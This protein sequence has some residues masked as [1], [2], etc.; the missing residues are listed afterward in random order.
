MN[1]IDRQHDKYLGIGIRWNQPL[2][3]ANYY[4]TQRKQGL[5]ERKKE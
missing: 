2:F 4:R 5:L 3:F 1:D